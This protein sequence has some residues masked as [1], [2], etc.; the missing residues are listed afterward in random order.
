MVK[1]IVE[2]FG[3]INE[4]LSGEILDALNEC[5]SRLQPH[6]V[7]IVD[8]YLFQQSS[9]MN[10]FLSDEKTRLGVATSPFD[11]YFMATHDAWRGTPRIMVALDTMLELSGLIRLGAI[12]HEAAHT[13][14]HGSLEYYI[15]PIPTGLRSG[16]L[17]FL[18][19]Q[20]MLDIVYL[21]SIAVKDCEVSR[22]LY[23]KGYLEDQVAYCKYLL[24]PSKDDLQAWSL[25]Q[26]DRRAR[27]LALVS[28]LKTACCVVPLMEDVRYGDEMVSAINRGTSYLPEASSKWLMRMLKA[29]THFGC[30]THRN[31]EM[32]MNKI[33]LLL[34][35][36]S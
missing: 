34:E 28:I 25:A 18:S 2:K 19:R 15:F 16:K 14:L 6:A 3:K 36:D 10:A 24:E 17:N 21:V 7:Q 5:Y 33:M 30:D 22:L 1:I 13:V 26:M 29:A 11:A 8:L 23:G 12:R 9:T 20:Y 35:E 27:L 31:V 32:L 4:G